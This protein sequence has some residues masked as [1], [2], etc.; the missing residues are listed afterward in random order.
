MCHSIILIVWIAFTACL[1]LLFLCLH[2]ST[3]IHPT[4]CVWIIVGNITIPILIFN[5][6]VI[7][8]WYS[9]K[10]FLFVFILVSC[11]FGN[12]TDLFSPLSFYHLPILCHYFTQRLS[13]LSFYLIIT[14]H[15]GIQLRFE[16]GYFLLFDMDIVFHNSD[17]LGVALVYG[18]HLALE[19]HIGF[20]R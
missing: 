3:V 18:F 10:E 9:L 7:K 16:I 6:D 19:G 14:I 2:L 8:L 17:L 20:M 13:E 15:E 4:L 1:Y 11:A 12:S 5:E